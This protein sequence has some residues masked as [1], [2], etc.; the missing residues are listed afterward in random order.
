MKRRGEQIAALPIRCDEKGKISV[1]MVTS[2]ETKRWV[3]PKGWIMDNK[4]PWAAAEI[5]ALEEAGAEEFIANEEL[6]IYHYDK[7]LDDKKTLRCRVRVYPMMVKKLKRNWKERDERKRHWFTPKAA[8]KRVH[9][10]DLSELLLK[11]NKKPHK[12]PSVKMVLK[13]S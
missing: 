4:K 3:L 8:A 11:L 7:V 2:R 1:L 9:E 13:A 10:P 6:G 12:E 5:E